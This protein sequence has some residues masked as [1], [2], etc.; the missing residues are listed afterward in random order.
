V[1][2]RN[3]ERSAGVSAE[4]VVVA[5]WQPVLTESAIVHEQPPDTGR[6]QLIQCAQHSIVG[7]TAVCGQPWDISTEPPQATVLIAVVGS[8]MDYADA[9]KRINELFE[10]GVAI[11]G[12]IVARDEAVLISARISRKVPV[13]DGADVD[14]VLRATSLFLEVRP[15]GQTVQT[16]TDVWA[17]RSA[18]ME[19]GVELESLG[20][21]ARW[22]KDERA[23]IIGILENA[24]KTEDISNAASVTWRSGKSVDL[25]SAIGNFIEQPV[26]VVQSLKLESTRKTADVW[27]VDLTSTLITRGI[28][29]SSKVHTVVTASLSQASVESGNALYDE[30][31]VPVT[32]VASESA[33]AA[34]GASTT[35]GLSENTLILDIG[36][37]TIDLVGDQGISAAGAGE[38][39]STAVAQVLDVPRGAADWIKRSP[40]RRLESPQVLLSEDGSR[41]FVSEE[42]A[43]IP[44]NSLGALITPGPGGFIPFG[45]GLQP[46]EWRIIRHS[47]KKEVIAENVGRI[48]RTYREREKSSPPYDIVI[49]GGPAA[50]DELLPVL[51]ELQLVGGLGRGNVAG[52]LG[53]RYAVAYGLTQSLDY[54]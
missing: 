16:A 34:V 12:V 14:A 47:L 8:S 39:L 28:R 10:S 50:D 43:T 45:Q 29:V 41:N 44:V 35:P 2:L 1:L 18:L 15:P 36:G 11:A 5:P 32:R 20:L 24:P 3:I 17:L 38:L 21:I 25:F 51:G 7:N 49:V 23:V 9:A 54:L 6:V 52:K 19:N 30:F 31:E 13:V 4:Q 46:A 40:A 37:G 27:G 48:L 33:A 53:H 42:D 26:G 22:V